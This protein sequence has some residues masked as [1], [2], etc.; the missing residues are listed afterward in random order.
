VILH[1]VAL[2]FEMSTAVCTPRASRA[3]TTSGDPYVEPYDPYGPGAKV[4]DHISDE[5]IED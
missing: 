4:I 1:D 2:E 3:G 5:F